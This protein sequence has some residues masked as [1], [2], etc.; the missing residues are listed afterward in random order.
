ML[1]GLELRLRYL[2]SMLSVFNRCSL[3]RILTKPII[4]SMNER[5]ISFIEEH[6]LTANNLEDVQVAELTSIKFQDCNSS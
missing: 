6:D 1:L 4:H 3:I 5:T 2:H